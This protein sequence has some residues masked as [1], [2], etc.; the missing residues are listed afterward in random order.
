MK[1][2]N[3]PKLPKKIAVLVKKGVSGC[4]LAELPELD[5][6]T[7]ADGLNHLFFQV[8]D[9]IYTYF[10]VPKKYQ[11]QITFIPSSVAQMKLVKIDKQ[12]PKPA[13]RISVKTFYDQELCKIAFSSL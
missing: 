1:K 8:N 9:L 11:D 3:F 7:E 4:L 12:K 13:T 2:V 5:I 10:N 6:F